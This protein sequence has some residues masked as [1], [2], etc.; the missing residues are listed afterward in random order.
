M[1]TDTTFADRLLEE[2]QETLNS[3]DIELPRN[4]ILSFTGGQ[5][6]RFP[7]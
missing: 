4:Y 2:P 7:L 1:M 6:A 3:Y 5:G